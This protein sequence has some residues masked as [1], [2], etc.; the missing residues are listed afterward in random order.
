MRAAGEMK[1]TYRS[2]LYV[3]SCTAG[4]DCRAQQP[5]YEGKSD[6]PR[7]TEDDAWCRKYTAY[8][9]STRRR[10]GAT[11]IPCANNAVKYEEDRAGQTW[12]QRVRLRAMSL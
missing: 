10:T 2:K 4:G 7:C 8:Y 1:T 11:T 6:T 9:L 3:Y 12:I 5:H